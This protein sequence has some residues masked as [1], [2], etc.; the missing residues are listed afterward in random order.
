[1]WKRIKRFLKQ[2]LLHLS[3]APTDLMENK[4]IE[5]KLKSKSGEMRAATS[6]ERLH[7]HCNG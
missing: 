5:E 3:G 2:I 4:Q 1:M 6:N 7:I